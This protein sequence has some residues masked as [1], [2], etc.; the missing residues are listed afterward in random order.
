M[1]ALN[2]W[3]SSLC[4][5]VADSLHV[6]MLSLFWS[7]DLSSHKAPTLHLQILGVPWAVLEEPVN[8]GL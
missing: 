6:T 2:S 8:N 7:D 1:S 4:V 5:A 3:L